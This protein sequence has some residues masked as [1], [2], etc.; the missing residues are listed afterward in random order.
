MITHFLLSYS[1]QSFSTR[2]QYSTILVNSVIPSAIM[3]SHFSLSHS[4][5]PFY[6]MSEQR[7]EH[8]VLEAAHG[9]IVVA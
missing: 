9:S 5:Q 7:H 2:L 8:A 1:A 3:L 6:K 4:A